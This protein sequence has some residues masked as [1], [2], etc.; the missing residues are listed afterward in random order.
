MKLNITPKQKAWLKGAAVAI[1]SA[2][3]SAVIDTI[4]NGALPSN[5]AGW[6]KFV[7]MMLSISSAAMHL[8]LKESPLTN[9]LGDTK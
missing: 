8:Y 2:L 9:I 5:K 4:K 6:F 1:G 7:G 3:S